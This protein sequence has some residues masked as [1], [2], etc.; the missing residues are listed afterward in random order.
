VPGGRHYLLYS[1]SPSHR[2]FNGGLQAVLGLR[3]TSALLHSSRAQRLFRAGDRAARRELADY[4]TG[5]WSLYSERGAES[6]LNYHS[7]TAGF[8]KGLCERTDARSYCAASRRFDRYEREPT[9]IGL[10]RLKGTRWDRTRTVRFTL[11]K[12]SSVKVRVWG[13]RGM[14]VTQDFAKLPR[15]S[16]S[17][18]WR[19]PGRGRY[20]VRIQAQGPS[21]PVGV[22]ERTVRVTTPAKPKKKKKK[23]RPERTSRPGPA[24]A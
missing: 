1:F 3:D 22:E 17:F 21:G 10:E 16:H 8:L 23:A 20:R 9:R 24:A 13:A 19:P 12:V 5:A 2:V 15:G 11:S 14:S 7:L 18:A 6:T 4:D